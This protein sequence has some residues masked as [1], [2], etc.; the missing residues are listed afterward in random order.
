MR[1]IEM[2]DPIDHDWRPFVGVAAAA[3]VAAR[4]GMIGPANA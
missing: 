1:A 2:D 3:I 4:L